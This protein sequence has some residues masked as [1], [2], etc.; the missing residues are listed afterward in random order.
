[1]NRHE[2]QAAE[3]LRKLLGVP[4]SKCEEIVHEIVLATTKEID[5]RRK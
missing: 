5:I 3:L 4:A 1:M 2:K